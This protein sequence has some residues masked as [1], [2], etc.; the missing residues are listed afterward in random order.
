MDAGDSGEVV[1][2]FMRDGTYPPRN[3][4]T[5][6]PSELQPPFTLGSIRGVTS[7]VVHRAPGRIQTPYTIAILRS[8]V[9]LVNSRFS[10]F[11]GAASEEELPPLRSTISRSYGMNLQ[12]S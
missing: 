7:S 10:P 5:L 4:A 2:S 6:G 8:P 3:F 1:T 9:F 11:R 12:S